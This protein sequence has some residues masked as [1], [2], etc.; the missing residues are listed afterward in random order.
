[1]FGVIDVNKTDQELFCGASILSGESVAGNVPQ[2]VEA[3][4]AKLH[5]LNLILI[6]IWWKRIGPLKRSSDIQVHLMSHF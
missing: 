3:L 4:A 1:V 5:N 2:Q 6:L